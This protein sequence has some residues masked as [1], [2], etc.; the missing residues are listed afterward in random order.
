VHFQSIQ[1]WRMDVRID[2]MSAATKY[3]TRGTICKGLCNVRTCH[4]QCAASLPASIWMHGLCF[5]Y[6]LHH[7]HSGRTPSLNRSTGSSPRA[8]SPYAL[9]SPSTS[10]A[11]VTKRTLSR[12]VATSTSSFQ[13]SFRLPSFLPVGAAHDS[14]AATHVVVAAAVQADSAVGRPAGAASPAV[15]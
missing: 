5:I 3:E 2:R 14:H 11:R 9:P 6:G 4:M 8:T 12:Y 1:A 13:M 7:I 15:D 10:G